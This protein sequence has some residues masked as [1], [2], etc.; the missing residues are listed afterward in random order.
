MIIRALL[1][2]LTPKTVK[3]KIIVILSSDFPL[4]IKELKQKIK[5]S[6]N[7]SVSYQS[8]HKELH[9]LM[10]DEIIICEEKKYL[11]NVE[12]IRQVGL[13][14]DLIISNYTSERKHS[15]NKL[16][17]LKKD[18]DSVSFDFDSYADVD[19]YFFQLLEYYNEFFEEEKIILHHY[20]HSWWPLLYPLREKSVLA[21]LKS[22]FY[23][24]CNSNSAIDNYCA[25]FNNSIGIKAIYT[26]DPKLHW[27]VN[28]FGDLIFTY[29]SDPEV[30]AE[31]DKFFEKYKD[32]KTIDLH[33]LTN[34]VQRKGR[35]R[36]LVVKDSLFAKN[37][38]A[39]ELPILNK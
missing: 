18:G 1:P 27:N 34:I 26:T 8:V 7:K 29:Y 5:S 20:P 15:I 32:F 28:L 39:S 6:F 17:E 3:E 2:K 25:N 19:S 31:V 23:C 24:V 33:L 21:K 14:S 37:V 13:F 30:S 35:F 22:P 16:L 10:T 11:L 38:L 4:T 12:W 9:Q 36:I